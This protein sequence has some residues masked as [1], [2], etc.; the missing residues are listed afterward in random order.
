[1]TRKRLSLIIALSLSATLLLTT[2]RSANAATAPMGPCGSPYA[3]PMCLYGD[4]S[5]DENADAATCY[6]INY[7]S[8]CYTG[9][10][11]LFYIECQDE[12]EAYFGWGCPNDGEDYWDQKDIQHSGYLSGVRVCW[13]LDTPS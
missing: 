4:E 8:S 11:P 1:M 3:V 13:F 12:L 9:S 7:Y 2:G 6:D 5:C 10:N